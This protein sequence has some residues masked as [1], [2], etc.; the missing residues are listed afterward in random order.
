MAGKPYM[1][2]MVCGARGSSESKTTDVSTC[3]GVLCAEGRGAGVTAVVRQL[4]SA[5]HSPSKPASR[6]QSTNGRSGAD[7]D[8]VGA[9]LATSATVADKG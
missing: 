1:N 8:A 5:S 9:L 2:G 3:S 7:K 6:G 4:K